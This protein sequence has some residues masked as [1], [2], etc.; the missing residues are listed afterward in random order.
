MSFRLT[1]PPSKNNFSV[2]CLS[3]LDNN[4]VERIYNFSFYGL[5]KVVY[6]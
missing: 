1:R 4:N 6:M 5:S 3:L 2:N